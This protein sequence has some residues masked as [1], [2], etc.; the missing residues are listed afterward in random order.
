MYENS[1]SAAE[2]V[3]CIDVCTTGETSRI[4]GK[5]YDHFS[6]PPARSGTIDT[7]GWTRPYFDIPPNIEGISGNQQERYHTTTEIVLYDRSQAVARSPTRYELP[8]L[9]S[10]HL[11]RDGDGAR[12][13]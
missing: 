8:S 5:C 11:R 9:Y 6:I 10:R 12:A 1:T 13:G 7:G 2:L 3:F 4:R